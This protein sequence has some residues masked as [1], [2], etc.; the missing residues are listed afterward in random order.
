[1]NDQPRGALHDDGSAVPDTLTFDGALLSDEGAKSAAADDFGHIVHSRPSLVLK[2]GSVEDVVRV[3][4]LARQRGLKIA[5]RGAGHS[6]LGQT[7]VK[8]GVVVDMSGLAKVL[9]IGPD[10]LTVEG[11][12]RWADVLGAAM[13]RGLTPPVLPDY[14]GLSVGGLL[15]VGGV[16]RAT[17]RYGLLVDTVLELDIVTGA[18][19]L[20]TCSP[21]QERELFEAALAG[22]GQCGILVSAT[23]RLIPAPE[24]VS[25]VHLLYGDL[26]IFLRDL[27]AVAADGRFDSLFGGAQ[28]DGEGR[29]RFALELGKFYNAPSP[30]DVAAL[31]ADLGHDKG[32][33]RVQ[34]QTYLEHVTAPGAQLEGLRAAGLW[35]VPHP[36]YDVYLPASTA[37]D[38]MEAALSALSPT[39]LAVVVVGALNTGRLTAPLA[40]V[41]SGDLAYSFDIARFGPRDAENVA[42]SMVAENRALYERARAIGGTLIAPAAVPMSPEDWERHFSASWERLVSAKRRFDPD[43]V[44]LCGRDVFGEA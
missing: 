29:W 39:E 3:V 6:V 22:L 2:A 7:Q 11:G 5:V 18:G 26:P 13:E 25:L 38:H 23:I 31:F 41:P 19:E 33:E 20:V 34:D 42:S 43:K 40:R 21:F 8:D 32:A 24:R 28:R 12:A 37:A 35:D 4:R 44:L 15:A 1:M 17:H 14:H 16:G 30:P 27:A 9:K 36:W 10:R